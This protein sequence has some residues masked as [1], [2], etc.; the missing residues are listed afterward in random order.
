MTSFWYSEGAM[1][2]SWWRSAR[3]ILVAVG[4]VG[5]TGCSSGAGTPAVSPTPTSTAAAPA[6]P[7]T[8]ASVATGLQQIDQIAKGIAESA[9]TDKAKA[10]DLDHQIEPVWMTIEDTVKK[11]DQNTYLTMEDSFE[12]LGKAANNGDAAAATKGATTISSAVQAYLAK[13]SG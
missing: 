6:Q 5:L 3:V 11:N 4:V 7:A 2:T 12:V 9:G 8:A 1:L 13:Y 10:A